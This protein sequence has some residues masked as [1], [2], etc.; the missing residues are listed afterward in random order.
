ML[1]PVCPV[2]RQCCFADPGSA[3]DGGDHYRLSV[4]VVPG[5]KQGVQRL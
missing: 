1:Y 2:H 4:L 5:W 3:I